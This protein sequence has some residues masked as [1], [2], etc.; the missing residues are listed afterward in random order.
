MRICTTDSVG[1]SVS[2]FEPRCLLNPVWQTGWWQVHKRERAI[3]I[4]RFVSAMLMATVWAATGF[5]K[6]SQLDVPKLN[7]SLGN[8]LVYNEWPD[9]AVLGRTEHL[10][11]HHN[12]FANPDELVSTD[13]SLPECGYFVGSTR[14]DADT[15]RR[16]SIIETTAASVALFI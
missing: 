6:H 3:L 9:K 14:L 1:Q 15:F 4:N 2:R 7:A 13:Q 11:L 12:L 10:I 5:W 8:D 16:Y